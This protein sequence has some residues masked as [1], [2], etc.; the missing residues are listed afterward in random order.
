MPIVEDLAGKFGLLVFDPQA[1]DPEH[2][3]S[4][5][6]ESRRTITKLARNNRNAIVTLLEHAGLP[7]PLKMPLPKSL[8]RWNYARTRK[9]L[10]VKCGDGVFVPTLF[11]I[12]RVASNQIDL[13]CE[14]T[15]DVPS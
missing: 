4:A 3:L 10:E 5:G 14:C 6:C 11:P 12:R 9:T 13:A 15:E 2:L 1:R 8:C 7:T